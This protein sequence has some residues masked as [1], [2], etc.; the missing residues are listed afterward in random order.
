MR[1]ESD[2]IITLR[3][4]F[5]IDLAQYIHSRNDVQ[6]LL[7]LGDLN[8]ALH[9]KRI[10]TFFIETGIDDV[11]F[12]IHNIQLKE[13]R[14][15][16]K[17]GITY[18][19]T[20]AASINLIPFLP[21]VKLEN[22]SNVMITDHSPFVVQF[23]AVT[24]FAIGLKILPKAMHLRL[25]SNKSTDVKRFTYKI[26]QLLKNFDL[27]EMLNQLEICFLPEEFEFLDETITW[28]FRSSTKYT[29]G[30]NQ[31]VPLSPN[32]IR[33]FSERI[34]WNKFLLAMV[35]HNIELEVLLKYSNEGRVLEI[36]YTTPKVMAQE[37]A[38]I[39]YVVA[40]IN[41]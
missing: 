17:I 32:K 21:Y 7:L 4:Y 5:F 30:N 22:Y 13:W 27:E 39:N 10:R 28:V 29:E 36:E 35:G 33:V 11:F 8:E 9:S 20:V 15:T 41:V 38:T 1:R 31:S 25:D 6:D 26:E 19:D 16:Y 14:N 37:L 40:K 34:Y 3:E 2:T 18:I 24:Y 12:T 23:Y